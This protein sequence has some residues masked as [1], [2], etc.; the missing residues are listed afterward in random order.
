MKKSIYRVRIWWGQA[1]TRFEHYCGSIHE[2]KNGV[3]L[4]TEYH[5]HLE[6][7]PPWAGGIEVQVKPDS[8]WVNYDDELH[9][10]IRGQHR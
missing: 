5:F 4:L 9:F 7:S 2:A 3:S 10:F 6:H 8:E 1:P